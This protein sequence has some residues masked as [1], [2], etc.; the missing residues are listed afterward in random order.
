[1]GVKKVTG[2]IDDKTVTS[3]Q[4]S[5]WDNSQSGRLP[6]SR[7]GCS[8]L[9]GSFWISSSYVGDSTMGKRRS[10]DSKAWRAS[11]AEGKEDRENKLYIGLG[12]SGPRSHSQ[13]RLGEWHARCSS[14]AVGW[15][16]GWGES[17]GKVSPPLLGVPFVIL[18]QPAYRL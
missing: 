1:M 4:R 17:S 14:G 16:W 2:D 13:I 18:H 10:S 11:S 5:A 3:H 8:G 7:D 15:G 9:H 6:S 12:R